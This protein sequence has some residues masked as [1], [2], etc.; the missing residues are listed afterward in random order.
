MN[1]ILCL[2]SDFYKL[3]RQPL[4]WIHL[5]IPLAGILFLLLSSAFSKQPAGSNALACPGAMTVA[6]PTLIGIVCS[7][8][9]EQEAEAGNYQSLLAAPVRL[10]PFLSLS[11]ML[12]LLGLSAALLTAFGFEA[13]FALILGQAPFGPDFYLRSVLLVFGCAVFLYFFH[14]FLSLRF[15]KGVSVGVGILESLASALLITGLGDGK[16][17]LIPCAWGL[18]FLKAMSLS[19]P[20]DVLPAAYGIKEGTVSCIVETGLMI[21]FSLL[22]FSRWEGA[23]TEE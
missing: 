2:R 4:L 13:G 20:G 5:F 9:A 8:A 21:V 3:K 18:R 12:L 11:A 16:W 19:A 22:W 1:F 6:F 17:I 10:L 23:K 7:L 15:N 14:L